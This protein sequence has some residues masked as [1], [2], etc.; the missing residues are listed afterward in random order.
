M[1][2]TAPSSDPD[3]AT[4]IRDAEDGIAEAARELGDR[5]RE[6]RGVAP[7]PALALLW[8]ETGAEAGDPVA[9]FQLGL[10]Y[11]EGT[12][13]V[14]DD[15]KGGDWI[16]ESAEQGYPP[17]ISQ[18]GTLFRLGRGTDPDLL[19]AA[20]L[21][22][23]AAMEDDAGA[24]A[25]LADYH[26]ELVALA[27]AGNRE[28]AFDLSRIHE[29]GLGAAKDPVKCWAWLRWARDTCKPMPAWQTRTDDLD[30]ELDKAYKLGQTTLDE[31]VRQ[32]GDGQWRELR[33][34]RGKPRS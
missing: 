27:L 23:A 10:R 26:G 9:Q 13:V 8:Y 11:L 3:I 34:A 14:Q 2:P 21:H 12:G 4:L 30:R 33:A 18:L 7:N 25:C 6:G 1:E 17:A 19:Q 29:L 15:L 20:Q 32:Q 31:Q 16:A 22:M 24:H 5:Y 28:A